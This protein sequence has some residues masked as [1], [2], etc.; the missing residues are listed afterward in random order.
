MA[1]SGQTECVIPRNFKLLR[2][3]E[4]GEKGV[5]DGTLSW[6]LAND[7]DITLSD[8]I[9]TIIGPPRTAFEGRIYTLKMHCGEKYPDQ[10]P[11]VQFQTRINLSCVQK[12]TGVVDPKKVNCLRQWS[13]NASLA[14]VLA[15]IRDL[16]VSKENYKVSQP[17]EGTTYF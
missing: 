17:A 11:T 9:G 14:D 15:G 2:E 1:G 10:P 16:M 7:S 4:L 12:D 6:G 5:G 13:R 3:L 8:W